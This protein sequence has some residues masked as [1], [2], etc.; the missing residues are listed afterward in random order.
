M[1]PPTA[2]ERKALEALQFE[3][4]ER[5][6]K[7]GVGEKIF[8]DLVAKGWIAPFQGHDHFGD[9]IVITDLGRAALTMPKPV[10]VR[11]APRL[12]ELPSTRLKPLKGR[13]DPPQG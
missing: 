1:T 6:A 10:K 12:K 9:K 13:F 11:S 8:S 7:L 4:W 2:R 3:E 5:K